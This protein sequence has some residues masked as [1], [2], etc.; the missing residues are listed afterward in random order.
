MAEDRRSRTDREPDTKAAGRCARQG[1]GTALARS[2]R[3]GSGA[4]RRRGTVCG[5]A[6]CIGERLL[7]LMR[8]GLS[9]RRGEAFDNG[10]MLHA[11]SS[12]RALR[13]LACRP[14]RCWGCCWPPRCWRR[15]RSAAGPS[16]AEALAPNF[17]PAQ[18]DRGSGAHLLGSRPD[19]AR[20]VAGALHRRGRWWRWSCCASSSTAIRASGAEPCRAAIGHALRSCGT[21]LIA[22]GGALA[23]IARDRCAAGA[24]AVTTSRMRMSTPGDPRGEQ[25]Q[26]RQSRDRRRACARV[27][28]V[29]ARKRMMQEVPKADVVIT[30]PTHYA[31]ALRY[32]DQRMRAPVV[33]AKGRDLIAP[34]HP[35]DRRRAQGGR[36][37]RR[38][39]WRG[40]CTPVCELGD[41]IP[42]RLYA[43]VA[44]VLIYVYQLRTA[45]R[46]GAPPPAPPQHRAARGVMRSAISVTQVALLKC[47]RRREFVAR[48]RHGN[49]SSSSH[50]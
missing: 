37:S 32:D 44:K 17:E 36:W 39:R 9:I 48:G 34:A 18:S 31:V 21:A 49:C 19:R 43:A 47:L 1:P 24:L 7:A 14:R 5:L 16:A 12:T 29:L 6:R 11:A 2:E 13:G 27:Q 40:R 33:V 28:Q 41:E 46:R 4:D 8:D 25:G 22:L 45:R 15:S 38:R 42:T 35:R 20:Q 3:R 50:G 30:N 10:R 26:R 23:V